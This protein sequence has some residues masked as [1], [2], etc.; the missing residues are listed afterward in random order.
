MSVPKSLKECVRE[1]AFRMGEWD[2]ERLAKQRPSQLW[3]YFHSVGYYVE[4]TWLKEG[5]A[6][7]RYLQSLG[8]E[9]MEDMKGM[10][11]AALYREI[12]KK[13][14]TEEILLQELRDFWKDKHELTSRDWQEEDKVTLPAVEELNSPNSK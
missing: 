6:L 10:V 8:L 14:V 1:L 5:S 2:R 13:P 11:V 9:S 4:T 12:R 3:K 7:Q